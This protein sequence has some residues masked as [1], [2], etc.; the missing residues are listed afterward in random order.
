[1]KRFTFLASAL[2]MASFLLPGAAM[3]A[4]YTLVI[5]N[6]RFE[7]SELMVPAG[8]RV[9]LVIDNRDATAEEFESHDLRREK[10]VPGNSKGE[11]WVGPLPAGKYHFYGEFH[12]DTAQGNLIAK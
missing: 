5:K 3:A 9:K 1:M 6:H 4:E 12:E 2:L 8:K 10:I 7:P 11:V